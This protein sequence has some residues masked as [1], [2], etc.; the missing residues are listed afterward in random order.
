MAN[1]NIERNSRKILR[2]LEA[3]GWRITASKGSHHKL[4]HP[5]FEYPIILVH[6]KKDLPIG[7][8]RKIHQDAGWL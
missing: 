1:V 3:D 7:L 4:R 5:D 8:A 2:R 6:P